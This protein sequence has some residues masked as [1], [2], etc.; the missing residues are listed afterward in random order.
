M[1][2]KPKPAHKDTS[3]NWE[4]KNTPT[5][6]DWLKRMGDVQARQDKENGVTP[7]RTKKKAAPKKTSKRR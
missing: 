2:T 7:P 6:K 4:G 3:A 1:A 5:N